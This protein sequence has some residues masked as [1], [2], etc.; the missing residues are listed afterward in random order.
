MSNID[1]TGKSLKG[2]LISDYYTSLLH[3]S[4]SN[5]KEGFMLG[6]VGNPLPLAIN[7]I[8]DG[9]GNSTGIKL[10]AGPAPGSEDL[11]TDVII[12]NYIA[13]SANPYVGYSQ[14]PNS[15]SMVLSPVAQAQRELGIVGNDAVIYRDWL[16]TFYP[17][18]SI[19]MTCYDDN[20]GNR[21]AGTKWVLVSEGR[22][23]VGVGTGTDS[24]NNSVTFSKEDDQTADGD[25]LG[26]YGNQLQSDQLPSHGHNL[27]TQTTNTPAGDASSINR[28]PYFGVDQN[29][30]GVEDEKGGLNGQSYINSFQTNAAGFRDTQIKG[31]NMSGYKYTDD[32]FNPQLGG[33]SL[34]GWSWGSPSNESA[35]ASVGVGWGGTDAN[36]V[37]VG[38]AR[39][40]GVDQGQGEVI[41][42]ADYD[43][44]DTDLVHPGK[45]PDISLVQIRN[46][47]V[48]ILGE[49]SA[50]AALEDVTLYRGI[51]GTDENVMTP[52]TLSYVT[53]NIPGNVN[54]RSTSLGESELHNNMAPC[55]GLYIWKRVP[56][57][58][59]ACPE[60]WWRDADGIC[61]E[62]CPEGWVRGTDG[63]CYDPKDVPPNVPIISKWEGI[64][65][66]NQEEL[67]LVQW[68]KSNG[69]NGSDEAKIT[70]AEGVY[71]YSDDAGP[72]DPKADYRKIPAIQ[73]DEFPNGLT[74]INN[75]FI[76]GRGGDGGANYS[77]AS[78]K[79]DV[80]IGQDGGDAIWINSNSS[81]VINNNGAI[82]GGGGGGGAS[83]GRYKNG[84]GSYNGGGGGAGGGWGGS[85]TNFNTEEE[86]GDIGDGRQRVEGMTG[87]TEGDKGLMTSGGGA[88][89][90][91]G[92]PGKNGRF[93]GD[94]AWDRGGPAGEREVGDWIGS[95]A[96]T[97]PVLVGPLVP[98]VDYTNPDGYTYTS[99]T[100]S[101][102]V[103]P[104]QGGQAG[105]SGAFGNRMNHGP[106]NH[107]TGGGGGRILSKTATGGAAVGFTIEY[108]SQA[109]TDWVGS[110]AGGGPNTAGG[111]A[112]H[113]WGS[114]GPF[115]GMGGGGGGGWGAPGGKGVGY[116]HGTDGG[117]GGFA[118]RKTAQVT[119]AGTYR[120]EGGLV[121]GESG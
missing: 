80:G 119:R 9:A 88:G 112:R 110:G 117:S 113:T 3:L 6:A 40:P 64:I 76:M 56:D 10:S 91:P 86:A 46:Y 98:G 7:P 75:G 83:A 95:S 18:G 92:A 38:G 74:L 21:I 68:A 99:D 23:P 59:E 2:A 67:N 55:F 82:A 118:I 12:S 73:I 26:E 48:S 60:G 20:P 102:V 52:Q 44:R 77:K 50:A 4:G 109:K 32:D 100:W 63:V 41:L 37:Y 85:G 11:S 79:A 84:Y 103:G 78:V 36:G 96:R 90:A 45:I 107:G 61:R 106:W 28:L 57:D 39:P 116:K 120:I 111:N 89:G 43:P 25:R 29:P 94:P 58:W 47:L 93:F 104:G 101:K 81:I 54:T 35:G 97:G 105:G 66:T 8:Y 13:P 15:S 5:V 62:P 72:G 27:N 16:D 14:L 22:Y 33:F 114:K 51:D 42:A 49:E 17:I 24:N 70:I 87:W 53:G 1:K 69:W 108:D 121:Y 71:I 34:K 19:Q 115:K 31:R 65:S 30:E